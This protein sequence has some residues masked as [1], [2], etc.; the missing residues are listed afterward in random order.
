MSA[1]PNNSATGLTLLLTMSGRT[2]TPFAD[3][4]SAMISVFFET[5]SSTDRTIPMN[6]GESH[7]GKMM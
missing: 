5:S 3:S 1:A 7:F 2:S 4:M 6:P